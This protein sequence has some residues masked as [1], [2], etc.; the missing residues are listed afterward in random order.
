MVFRKSQNDCSTVVSEQS[1][2]R[3]LEEQINLTSTPT[4][5]KE[6]VSEMSIN[7]S[8]SPIPSTSAEQS[9][10]SSCSI[11]FE[12]LLLEQ[13]K[14]TPKTATAG[15]KR[16][17]TGA[18]VITSVGAVARLKQQI[19]E[20]KKTV[21]STSKKKGKVVKINRVYKEER[22]DESLEGIEENSD[23]YYNLD[24]ELADFCEGNEFVTSLDRTSGTIEKV[25]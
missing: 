4:A 9:L 1:T 21:A 3:V 5:N 18:E 23:N 24:D 2:A 22:D 19:K 6:V 20:P 10:T 7:S 13:L 14:Q 11:S 12:S 8:H 15:R 25:D 16:I 17:C